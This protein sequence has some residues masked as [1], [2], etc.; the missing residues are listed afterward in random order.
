[1]MPTKQPPQGK[2]H[3]QIESKRKNVFHANGNDRKTGVT[4]VL[5]DIQMLKQSHKGKE[6]K[7]IMVKGSMQEEDFTLVN[8]YCPK[9]I[10][11]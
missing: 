7:Y 9:H 2:R 6:G 4:I 3:T 5:S 10:K 1:M 11:Y 8:I